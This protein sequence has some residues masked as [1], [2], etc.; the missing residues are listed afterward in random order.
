MFISMLA[1]KSSFSF[2]KPDA[3]YSNFDEKSHM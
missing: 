3:F 1:V 2:T